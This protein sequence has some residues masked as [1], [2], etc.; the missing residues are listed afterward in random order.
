VGFSLDLDSILSD[1][2]LELLDAIGEL[3]EA[4]PTVHEWYRDATDAERRRVE[5]LLARLRRIRRPPGR[6]GA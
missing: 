1:S 4:A 2:Q 5:E 3:M 6:E